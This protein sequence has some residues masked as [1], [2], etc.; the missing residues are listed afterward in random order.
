MALCITILLQGR[1]RAEAPRVTITPDPESRKTRYAAVDRNR[2]E[3]SVTVSRC[4]VERIM[5]DA[6]VCREFRDLFRGYGL[7][8]RM[9]SA[10]K[11]LVGRPGDMPH[12]TE[13]LKQGVSPS[14][15]LPYDVMTWLKVSSMDMDT[16]LGG[17]YWKTDTMVYWRW[18]SMPFTPPGRVVKY[19]VREVRGADAAT[20]QSLDRGYSMDRRA[21]Y[22]EPGGS[23]AGTRRPSRCLSTEG[24]ARRATDQNWM[25]ISNTSSPSSSSSSSFVL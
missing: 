22:R 18:R 5:E 4:T 21:V 13:L 2:R 12:G 16:P 3:I 25:S 9:A 24:Q 17:G 14:S 15:R 6:M 20:W 11:V 1:A 10:E 8:L 7:H 19:D 23:W